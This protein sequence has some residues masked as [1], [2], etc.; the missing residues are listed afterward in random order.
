M[1]SL[2]CVPLWIRCT[3]LHSG[4]FQDYLTALSAMNS[5]SVTP[6]R[7]NG[8]VS[9]A[10]IAE[11]FHLRAHNEFGILL[12]NKIYILGTSLT[13]LELMVH[14]SSNLTLKIVKKEINRIKIQK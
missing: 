1:Q 9:F 8:Y 13:S 6:G 11:Y 12:C 4:V 2:F 10:G 3:E 14:D 7:K 5:L